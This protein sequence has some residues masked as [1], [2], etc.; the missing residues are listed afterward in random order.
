M[1]IIFKNANIYSSIVGGGDK[2]AYETGVLDGFIE[3]MS[4]PQD[5]AYDVVSGVSTGSLNAM[6][7]ALFKKGD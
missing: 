4:S 6:A 3:G 2:A 7:F 5:Y 1:W